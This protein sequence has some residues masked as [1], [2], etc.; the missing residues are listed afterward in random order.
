MQQVTY[1]LH[2][3]K[4]ISSDQEA[5]MESATRSGSP[6]LRQGL[7]F[8][9]ILAVAIIAFSFISDFLGSILISDLLGLAIYVVIG[10]LA[11]RRASSKTG[12]IGTGVLAGLLAGL[13]GSIISSILPLALTFSN[14]DQA[15]Q[16]F[17]Q[18]A[19]QAGLHVTYTNDLVIQ[20]VVLQLVFAAVLAAL[21]TLGG[22]ALGGYFGR[23]RAPVPQQQEYQE[24]MFEPPS[25]TPPE[26]ETPVS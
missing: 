20:T 11:G 5:I 21:L 10:L 14:L 25:P 3:Y 1:L 12:R 26:D 13:I 17:Q 18:A 19:N 24:A 22:G 7:I 15:R 4:I 23:G 16:G 8:G 9:I 2:E 6:A